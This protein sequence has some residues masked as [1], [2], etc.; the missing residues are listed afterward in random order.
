MLENTKYEVK[1]FISEPIFDINIEYKKIY[2]WLD[3][4]WLIPLITLIILLSVFIV[5]FYWLFPYQLIWII[6]FL[7]VYLLILIIS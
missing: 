4:I 2:G 5:L 7:P 1:Q 3:L 6:I